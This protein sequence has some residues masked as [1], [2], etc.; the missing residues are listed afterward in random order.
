MVTDNLRRRIEIS[1]RG[2]AAYPA[3][4]IRSARYD[5]VVRRSVDLEKRMLKIER[6]IGL[7]QDALLALISSVFAFVA[8][9]YFGGTSLWPEAIASA[10]LAFLITM[11]MTNVFF[12]NLN[13]INC[14]LMKR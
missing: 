1:K 7:L 4:I 2:F 14:R 3:R 6:F 5:A 13:A 10:I 9:M 11:W 8:V 12:G